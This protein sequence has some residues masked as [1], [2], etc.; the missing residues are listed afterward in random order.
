MFK[1]KKKKNKDEVYKVGISK[2]NTKHLRDSD[3]EL[4]PEGQEILGGERSRQRT[5]RQGVRIMAA[6]R[7]GGVG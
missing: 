1:K 2:K 4:A 3:T 6:D 5:K 7:Q